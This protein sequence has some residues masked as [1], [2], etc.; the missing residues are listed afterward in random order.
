LLMVC[1]LLPIGLQ[2]WLPIRVTFSRIYALS[3]INKTTLF[4]CKR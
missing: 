2:A 3:I 4:L 1:W